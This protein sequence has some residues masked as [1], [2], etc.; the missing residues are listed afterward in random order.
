MEK[1][2]VT[3]W[4]SCE[5]LIKNLNEE[6]NTKQADILSR[7]IVGKDKAA[8]SKKGKKQVAAAL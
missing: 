1:G 6:G 2:G 8:G 3:D 7:M 5:D 4:K